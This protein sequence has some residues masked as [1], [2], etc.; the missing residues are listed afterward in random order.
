MGCGLWLRLAVPSGSAVA[1]CVTLGT[2]LFGCENKSGEQTVLQHNLAAHRHHDILPAHNR[3]SIANTRNT[4][5]LR[6]CFAAKHLH[7]L[8]EAACEQPAMRL[9]GSHSPEV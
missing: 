1:G 4:S 8:V 6:I 5:K 3:C 9:I 2:I 7:C